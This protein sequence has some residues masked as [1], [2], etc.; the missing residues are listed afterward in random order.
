MLKNHKKIKYIL[1]VDDDNLFLRIIGEYLNEAGYRYVIARDGLQAW[2]LLQKY[3]NKFFVVLADRVM[4]KLHGLELLAKMKHT[5]LHAIPLILFTGESSKEER[6]DAIRQ[7][8]YDF[9]YK[10]LSKEL[11]LAILKKL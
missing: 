7:G 8:V 4:P 3:R 9:F 10:P 11:L 5:S 6:Y 2:S 1:V